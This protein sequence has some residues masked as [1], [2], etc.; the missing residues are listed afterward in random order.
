MKIQTQNKL[1]HLQCEYQ[2]LSNQTMM[3]QNQLSTLSSELQQYQGYTGSDRSIISRYK[4]LCTQHRVLRNQIQRNMVRLNKLQLSINTEIA[5]L[6][7]Y[8]Q[9]RRRYY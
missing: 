8:T 4:K 9:P 5:R 3:L 6:N 7:G 2:S 1:A